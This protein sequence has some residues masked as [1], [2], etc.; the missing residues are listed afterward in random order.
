MP[1]PASPSDPPVSAEKIRL[2][3]GG[4]LASGFVWT[5]VG[6]VVG[7]GMLFLS[8]AW[9]A[10]NLSPVE[11]GAWLLANNILSVFCLLA[12]AGTN[13]TVVR[14]L[15]ERFIDEDYG[16]GQRL[17]GRVAGVVTVS[18]LLVS[19][20][21]A[22]MLWFVGYRFLQVPM[23][24]PLIGLAVIVLLLRT[25]QQ[26]LAEVFRGFHDLPHASL[27]SGPT[28]SAL[29]NTVFLALL[30]VVGVWGPLSL[31]GVFAAAAA[32]LLL[33]LPL[34]ARVLRRALR[35]TRQLARAAAEAAPDRKSP[36]TPFEGV[37]SGDRFLQVSLALMF[38]QLL[39]F[40]AQTSDV[41]IAGFLFEGTTTTWY[42]TAKQLVMLLVIPLQMVNMT[43]MSV[44]P[45]LHRQGRTEQLSRVVRSAS[46][47]S[48]AVGMMILLP[49]AIDPVF[50]LSAVYGPAYA[51]ASGPLVI[52]TVG[53]MFNALT[54][55][56][57]LTLMMTG[58]ERVCLI[59]NAVAVAI[60]VVVGVWA[61]GR[62]GVTGLAATT[63]AVLAIQNLA[64]LV[65][66]R[67]LVGVWTHPDLSPSRIYEMSRAVGS[68]VRAFV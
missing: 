12:M 7:V 39:G 24:A 27:H 5:I 25:V 51:A 64:L 52:L 28:G 17:L 47:L 55:S 49:I 41:W 26:L 40:A 60:M 14:F 56:C 59:A 3:D 2:P 61:A 1:S 16:G 8:T 62:F 22:A 57:G 48:G 42:M 65:L 36:S 45:A 58:Y 15:A 46:T 18:S 29:S 32:S 20:L 44:I 4:A 68:R 30:L 13:R 66:T 11:L 31:T 19:A 50:C 67:R 33:V 53:Q 23:T 35:R 37:S 54:G 34:G 6:R 10:R 43:V 63:S 21:L 9:L 38:I